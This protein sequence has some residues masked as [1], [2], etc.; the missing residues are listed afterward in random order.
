MSTVKI[1]SLKYSNFVNY[2]WDTTLV[3]HT[4]NYLIVKGE[5]NRK[6][7]HY[8]RGKVFTMENP[9]IEF[10]PLDDWFTVSVE[11]LANDSLKYYCNICK[12]SKFQDN[13]LSFID[14]DFDIIKH[15]GDDWTVVDEDEFIINSKKYNYPL[16]LI[17]KAIEEKN[18]LLHKIHNNIF[19]FD[20]WIK[21]I[22]FDKLK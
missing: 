16:Q 22:V 13:E 3:E 12:P 18:K 19:P 9:A 11:K 2:E 20:G 1:K 6:L 8:G 10:F 5:I 15:P 7:V 17:D 14:L 4:E 21:E